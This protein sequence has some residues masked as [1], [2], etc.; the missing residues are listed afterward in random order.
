VGERPPFR[1]DVSV[2]CGTGGRLWGAER[3]GAGRSRAEVEQ[4]LSEVLDD[5]Q[6][7]RGG[8]EE[9]LFCRLEV[10]PHGVDDG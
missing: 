4:R 1:F 5:M 10:R 7:Y 3:G 9:G 8:A 2:R 6:R